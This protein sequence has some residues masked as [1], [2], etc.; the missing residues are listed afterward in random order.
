M[1]RDNKIDALKYILIILVIIGHTLPKFGADSNSYIINCVYLFHMPLFVMLSGY[2]SHK[3]P[4]RKFIDA[5]F[6]LLA[7]L[8]MFE[9]ICALLSLIF[10]HSMIP[11]NRPYWTF[12]YI[13]CLAI[14]RSFVQFVP[15]KMLDYKKMVLLICTFTCFT[16]PFIPLG[17][18]ASFQRIFSFFPFF[19]IGYYLNTGYISKLRKFN[20]V[21]PI[22]II[23]IG[24]LAT[25]I[26]V[27]RDLPVLDILRGAKY[28]SQFEQNLFVLLSY[29]GI[30]FFLSLFVSLSFISITRWQPT[31]SAKEGK[32]SL[33]YY[34]YHGVIIEFILLPISTFFDIGNNII[35]GGIASIIC[36]IICSIISK[37]D[38]FWSIAEPYKYYNNYI[39]NQYNGKEI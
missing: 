20:V 35:L 9:F 5:T 18:T 7:S 10:K 37:Y 13:F 15:K 33:I 27:N 38:I 17:Y 4:I 2:L 1:I 31:Y 24:F 29:K 23:V 11:I 22:S 25:I 3:Q 12:W 28:Y 14:W 39:M 30:L 32:K 6:S 36:I 26:I 8:F 21:F 19:L 34:L 16:T